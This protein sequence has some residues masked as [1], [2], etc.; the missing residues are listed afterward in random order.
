[1]HDNLKNLLIFLQMSQVN[2]TDQDEQSPTN[3]QT[4]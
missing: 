4:V 2:N 1:M 3:T